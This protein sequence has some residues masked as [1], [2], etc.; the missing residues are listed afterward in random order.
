VQRLQRD[1][2][3]VPLFELDT[4]GDACHQK[5]DQEC[6]FHAIT[7]VVPGEPPQACG[8]TAENP[9]RQA[10]GPLPILWTTDEFQE[11]REILSGSLPHLAEVA[12]SP[13]S[14]EGAG[15]GEIYKT[16]SS[17]SFV[18]PTDRTFLERG[19]E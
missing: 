1:P 12:E 19:G 8:R 3:G 10:P 7:R 11:H 16:S 18:A 15:V 14:R 6:G 2:Q 13:N 5:E 17:L 9:Q 4:R